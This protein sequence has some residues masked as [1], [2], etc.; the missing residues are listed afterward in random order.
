MMESNMRQAFQATALV[1]AVSVQML[2]FYSVLY[3]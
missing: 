2:T 3:A 1:V